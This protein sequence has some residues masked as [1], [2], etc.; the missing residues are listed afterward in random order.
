MPGPPPKPAEQRRRRNLAPQ[1]TKL[2][3][4]GRP[5]P[6]PDWP[7][8]GRRNAAEGRVWAEVWATPQA[9][10]WER[11]GWVRPVA[12]YVR[13]LVASEKPAALASL[14]GE[15]RQLEDRLGLSPMSMLR[16]RWEIAPDEIAELREEKTP[17]VRLVEAVDPATKAAE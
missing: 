3:P 17:R 13:C 6:P 5:G 2:P 10:A 8:G 9:A 15:V 14:L 4:E 12:R 7:L 16:L 11:L 1:T